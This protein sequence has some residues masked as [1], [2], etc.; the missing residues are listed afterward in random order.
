MCPLLL[1]AFAIF[2]KI[3]GMHANINRTG[4]AFRNILPFMGCKFC[5]YSHQLSERFE[6]VIEAVARVSLQIF[7][8][9]GGSTRIIKLTEV[10]CG[11][12]ALIEQQ[13]ERKTSIANRRYRNKPK[14]RHV[15]YRHPK[16]LLACHMVRWVS[17]TTSNCVPNQLSFSRN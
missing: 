12:L 13:G 16:Y 2:A 6:N 15:S 3:F 14:N 11:F 9:L 10:Y 4:V 17:I 8:S 1:A 7:I 5:N